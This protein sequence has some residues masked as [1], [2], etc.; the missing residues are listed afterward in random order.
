MHFTP[1]LPLTISFVGL[2]VVLFFV[3]MQ[4]IFQGL[5]RSRHGNV[6]GMLILSAV[7]I[8][9]WLLLLA[10]LA[11]KGFFREWSAM[12]PH[13]LMAPIVPLLVIVALAFLPAFRKGV[14]SIP[15]TWPVYLQAFRILVEILLWRLFVEGFLP[16]RMTP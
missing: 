15:S 8:M 5:E 12:P 9:G 11:V 3:L 1:S 4:G 14:R 2:V 13:I 10:S 7:G 16:R 6:R